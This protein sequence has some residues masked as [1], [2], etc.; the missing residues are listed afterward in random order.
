LESSSITQYAHLT[1]DGG[2]LCVHVHAQINKFLF[3]I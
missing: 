3:H 1:C 2:Y